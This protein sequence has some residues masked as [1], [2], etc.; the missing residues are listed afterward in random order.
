VKVRESRTNRFA[1]VALRTGLVYLLVPLTAFLTGPI[2]ARV[3]GPEGRGLLA[4]VLAPIGL[5]TLLL[6]F[7]IPEATTH[8]AARFPKALRRLTVVSICGGA[9]AGILALVALH[10]YAD[11]AV[12]DPVA[13]RLVRNLSW[14]LPG[15]MAVA[16]L[17]AVVLGSSRFTTVNVE[18]SIGAFA[19]LA[20]IVGLAASGALTIGTAACATEGA[21]LV[22]ALLVVVPAAIRL[23]TDADDALPRPGRMI[24]YGLHVWPGVVAGVVLLRADQAMMLPLAGAEQL[25][26]YAVAVAIAEVLNLGV[27]ALRDVLLPTVSKD[28]NVDVLTRASRCFVVLMAPVLLVTIL[29]VPVGLP[30]LYGEDFTPAVPMAQILCLSALPFG[31]SM[32]LGAGLMA[33]RRPG[34]TSVVQGISAVVALGGLVL[35]LPLLGGR[36]AAL[37]S[38]IAYAMGALLSALICRRALGVSLRTLVVPRSSDLTFLVGLVRRG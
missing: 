31:V 29:L 6:S 3:L 5:V 24:S 30:L 32:L 36:G 1:H 21:V 34:L 37:V 22:V 20:L 26:L 9:A 33:A 12:S 27:I 17:R 7:G 23:S 14:L 10:V 35:L 18:R 2:L 28:W 11:V 16:A 8:F 13:Q 15:I 19:R 38:L 25:G 4:G